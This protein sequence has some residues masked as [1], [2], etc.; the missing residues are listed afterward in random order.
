MYSGFQ[1][2]R[3]TTRQSNEL[4]NKRSTRNDHQ[5]H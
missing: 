1:S 3:W 5:C 2:C 4:Q